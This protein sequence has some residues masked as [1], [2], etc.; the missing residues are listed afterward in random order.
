M[1]QSGWSMFRTEMKRKKVNQSLTLGDLRNMWKGS[2]PDVRQRYEALA[3]DDNKRSKAS[4]ARVGAERMTR[5]RTHKVH[6]SS[7]LSKD[8]SSAL[9]AS[10]SHSHLD[11]HLDLSDSESLCS[12]G[13]CSPCSSFVKPS[14][15][16]FPPATTLPAPYPVPPANMTT[17]QASIFFHKF[18]HGS[19]ATPIPTS[20]ESL[21]S[22]EDEP[23]V[24]SLVLDR[25]H[26][27]SRYLLFCACSQVSSTLV[28]S[29]LTNH[30][31]NHTVSAG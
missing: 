28:K 13:S 14:R 11:S 16:P 20:T 19:K 12:R 4:A 26:A 2:S 31:S 30:L 27:L 29:T 9:Q 10:D 15:G 18:Y 23:M 6:I 3:N 22:L 8:I 17:E 1:R 24:R 25:D 7:P 5:S 21:E